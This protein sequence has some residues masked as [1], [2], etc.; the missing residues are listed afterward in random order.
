MGLP[1]SPAG[2]LTDAAQGTVGWVRR[3][4]GPCPPSGRGRG[5]GRPLQSLPE[6][7]EPLSSAYVGA[8]FS[9]PLGALGDTAGYSPAP[10]PRAEAS[11]PQT[12]VVS[13][14]AGAGRPLPAPPCGLTPAP[15]A[16]LVILEPVQETKQTSEAVAWDRRLGGGKGVAHA[17]LSLLRSGV[18]Q[19]PPRGLKEVLEVS[20]GPGCP[21]PSRAPSPEPCGADRHCAVTTTCRAGGELG[22]P[23][24]VLGGSW[25][26]PWTL[27][28]FCASHPGTHPPNGLGGQPR[29]ERGRM[30]VLVAQDI[31][32]GKAGPGSPMPCPH[33]PGGGAWLGGAAWSPGRVWG[34]CPGRPVAA[35][36]GPRGLTLALLQGWC[37]LSCCTTATS[38]ACSR[39]TC[40][41]A[42]RASIEPPKGRRPQGL[43]T[44]RCP[45]AGA[46]AGGLGRAGWGGPCW[47]QLS[48]HGPC[49]GPL[50]AEGAPH[51]PC[52]LPPNRVSIKRPETRLSP[53][54]R[55][56][57][58]RALWGLLGVTSICAQGL[59]LLFFPESEPKVRP[60]A[61]GQRLR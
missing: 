4:E 30:A 14:P 5:A 15:R 11:A 52:S 49:E 3:L 46:E 6:A 22:A 44:P 51:P 61:K 23:P 47:A 18:V 53:W 17:G 32:A 42:R 1:V 57:G 27:S 24:A 45:Q 10:A 19:R 20:P 31:Y 41:T 29:L 28:P 34:A 55:Q 35:S 9:L 59:S 56:L 25:G 58:G 39:G 54:L 36:W 12:P 43:E 8:L 60:G 2:I 38:P 7:G 13:S 37:W 16:P 48:G 40:S 26:L 21:R 50:R 33:L